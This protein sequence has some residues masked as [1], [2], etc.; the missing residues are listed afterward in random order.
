MKVIN[1]V[2]FKTVTNE[3]EEEQE[4]RRINIMRDKDEREMK[5][6]FSRYAL[7]TRLSTKIRGSLLGYFSRKTHTCTRV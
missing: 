2:L 3:D 4:K 1:Y 5:K 7:S 6:R